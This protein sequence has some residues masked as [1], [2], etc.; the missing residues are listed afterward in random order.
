MGVVFL[1]VNIQQDDWDDAHEF[2]KGFSVSYPAVRDATGEIAH[3]YQGFGLPTTYFIDKNGII[4][5]KYVGG[6]VG[7]EG[8]AELER[9]I[10]IILP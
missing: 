1:G 10:L 6:F 4:R 9:R 5:S 8:M 2:L 7:K 3:R